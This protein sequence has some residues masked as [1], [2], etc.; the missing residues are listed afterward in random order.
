MLLAPAPSYFERTHGFRVHAVFVLDKSLSIIILLFLLLLW[1]VTTMRL[2]AH[3]YIH[4]YIHT[5][6]C[7][8]LANHTLNISARYGWL[9]TVIRKMIRKFTVSYYNGFGQPSRRSVRCAGL[10]AETPT[11][12]CGSEP[13]FGKSRRFI[14]GTYVRVRPFLHS[15]VPHDERSAPRRERR[16]SESVEGEAL[17]HSGPK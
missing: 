1:F 3:T 13:W 16:Y 17:Q 4:A 14:H 11:M 6:N 5:S 7:P 8:D 15:W 2:T 12:R 9:L 10:F